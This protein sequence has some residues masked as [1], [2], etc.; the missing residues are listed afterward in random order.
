[1]YAIAID[2]ELLATGLKAGEVLK[3]LKVR[4]NEAKVEVA[5]FVPGKG[6]VQVCLEQFA[7]AA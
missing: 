6:W 4:E 7:H 2:G 5:C 1:M 3:N